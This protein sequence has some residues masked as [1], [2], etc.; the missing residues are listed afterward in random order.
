MRSRWAFPVLLVAAL[1]MT[2]APAAA[3]EQKGCQPLVGSLAAQLEFGA[4]GPA[5]VGMG[6]L[7]FGGADPAPYS[8]TDHSSGLNEKN[9]PKMLSGSEELAFTLS[10]GNT[11]VM[12]VDFIG[13][14]SPVP[15]MGAYHASG[16]IGGG[17]GI[18]AGATGVVTIQGEAITALPFAF[19]SWMAQ[20]HGSI[21]GLQ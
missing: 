10:A 1:L 5:W 21:C 11:L 7:S 6:F 4:G 13:V 15:F 3:Q 8:L 2:A 12:Q 20:I 17:T 9:N 18:Y 16:T 14:A 19:T